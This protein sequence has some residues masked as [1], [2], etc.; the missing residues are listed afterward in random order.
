MNGYCLTTIKTSY[1]ITDL[2]AQRFMQAL[3]E[4]VIDFITMTDVERKSVRGGSMVINDE[5]MSRPSSGRNQSVAVQ[6]SPKEEQFAAINTL[7]GLKEITLDMT[8][9]EKY[10]GAFSKMRSSVERFTRAW[11]ENPE[12]RDKSV[13][14]L[15]NLTETKEEFVQSMKVMLE[16]D[17][18][19]EECLVKTD[20]LKVQAQT[21]KKRAIVVNKTMKRRNYCL[22]FVVPVILII[23]VGLLIWWLIKKFG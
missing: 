19:I 12:N 18:K 5:Y 13:T 11:N 14:V 16:R 20:E 8:K 1:D 2:E 15:K 21:L 10:Y 17:S 7:P 23:L 22:K 9:Q 6:L 4:H 3:E